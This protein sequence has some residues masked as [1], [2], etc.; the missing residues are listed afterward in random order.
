M[1]SDFSLHSRQKLTMGIVF[2]AK[3]I[4]IGLTIGGIGYLR[5]QFLTSE[6]M[7]LLEFQDVTIY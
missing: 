4:R 6:L 2:L 7:K 5:N 1:I 3:I